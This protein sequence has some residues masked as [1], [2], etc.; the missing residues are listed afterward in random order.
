MES[1]LAGDLAQVGVARLRLDRG[2]AAFPEI[3]ELGYF[4]T[5]RRGTGRGQRRR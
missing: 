5:P 3:S 4:A 1:V 2:A